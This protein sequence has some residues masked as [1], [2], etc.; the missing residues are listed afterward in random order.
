MSR[1]FTHV[2]GGL[3]IAGLLAPTVAAQTSRSTNGKRNGSVHRMEIYNGLNRTVRYHGDNV[4]PGEV[5]T[6]REMERIENET[7][8]VQNLTALKQQYVNGERLS[9][10]HRRYVQQLLYGLQTTDSRSSELAVGWGGGWGGGGWGWNRFAPYVNPFYSLAGYGGGTGFSGAVGGTHTVSGTLA[11]GVGDEGRI[12]AAL[13]PVLAQ[14]ATPEYATSLDRAY[15]R[16]VLR[17]SASPTLRVALGLPS[18]RDAVRERSDI[19]QAANETGGDAAYVLTLKDG[20]KLRATR[21]DE[22]NGWISVQLVGGG[23]VKI[24]EAE[25][26]RIDA[27]KVKPIRPA[28]DD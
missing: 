18:V 16:V 5:L 1:L 26:V 4:S 19:R 17:A 7:D 13:A 22:G 9:E 14:Q 27:S 2:L 28:I 20:E 23:A 24:R 8:Y 6:L 15:D 21:V 10:T 3:F 11:D 12:K 25:V